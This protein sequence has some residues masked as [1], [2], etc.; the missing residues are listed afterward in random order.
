MTTRSKETDVDA[1][2]RLK[3][4]ADAAMQAAQQAQAEA[5]KTLAEIRSAGVEAAAKKAE[6]KRGFRVM[7]R[8]AYLDTQ[9][10]KVAA[11]QQALVKAREAA[12]REAAD[13]AAS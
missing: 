3:A 9:A 6:Q 11:E 13:K 2:K 10:E 7:S 5:Q 12:E 4:E 8:G 1:V